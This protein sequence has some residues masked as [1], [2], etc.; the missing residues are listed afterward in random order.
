MKKSTRWAGLIVLVLVLGGVFLLKSN[1]NQELRTT[2]ANVVNGEVQKVA[3]SEKNLN[4]FPNE[5]RVKAGQPVSISLDNTVTGCLR[6]FTIKELGVSKL[7]RTSQET[8]DFTPTKKGTFGFACIMGMG[9]G[10][11]IVE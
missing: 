4:Y 5:I 10:K 8:I 1:D 2:T 6:S 11:I 7:V 9:Y 3:L